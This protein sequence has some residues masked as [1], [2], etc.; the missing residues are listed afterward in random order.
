M[1]IS[2]TPFLPFIVPLFVN[3]P[4]Y[5]RPY[6]AQMRSG[7]G[8]NQPTPLRSFESKIGAAACFSARKRPL[9]RLPATSLGLRSLQSTPEPMATSGWARILIIA[10]PLRGQA[11]AAQQQ[12]C[13]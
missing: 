4:A 10:A 1:P 11:G 3:I 2:K 7:I 9:G 6:A 13:R 8:P 12:P 5:P